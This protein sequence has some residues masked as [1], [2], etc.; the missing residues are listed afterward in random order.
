MIT[1][2]NTIR[3]KATLLQILRFKDVLADK[4]RSNPIQRELGPT[5]DR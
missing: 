2:N 1:R 3:T 4:D 5:I